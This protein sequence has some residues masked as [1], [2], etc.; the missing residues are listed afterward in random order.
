MTGQPDP[1]ATADER[2]RAARERARR[3]LAERDAYWTDE[4]WAE[5]ERREDAA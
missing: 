5:F 3:V 1:T 2:R 4:R